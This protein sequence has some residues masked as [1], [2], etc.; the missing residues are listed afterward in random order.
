MTQ[1]AEPVF[2][3]PIAEVPIGESKCDHTEPKDGWRVVLAGKTRGHLI[4]NLNRDRKVAEPVWPPPSGKNSIEGV[5]SGSPGAWPHEAHHL[6]PW[7]QLGKHAVKAHLKKGSKLLADANYSVNHG[8]N[9]KFLPFAS[10]LAEWRKSK[11]K[12][13]LAERLMSTVGLQLHQGRHSTASFGG[14]KK[15]YK[16]RVQELLDKI[17]D[18]ELT[19]LKVCKECLGKKDGSKYP[20][21]AQMTR[22]VDFVSKRLDTEING[23]A[24][25]VSKRAYLA[26]DAGSIG[27]T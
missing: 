18:S 3:S 8:N 20:P 21:R 24:I 16:A 10:D 15:G 22:K 9:G 11:D 4:E 27:A 13:A 6:V 1:V 25:F 26:W 7:Q 2:F 5:I 19:H 12:Q 17:R 14:G 23:G